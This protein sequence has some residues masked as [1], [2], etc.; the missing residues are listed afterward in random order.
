[1]K[2][3]YLSDLHV[4]DEGDYWETGNLET[5]KKKKD[6]L[7]SKISQIREAFETGESLPEGFSIDELIARIEEIAEGDQSDFS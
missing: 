3:H 4:R 7:Q 1:M 2:K 5:L 6:F